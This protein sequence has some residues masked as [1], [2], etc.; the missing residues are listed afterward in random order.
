MIIRT[1]DHS[2]DVVWT[3]IETITISYKKTLV[4][5][6]QSTHSICHFDQA[7]FLMIEYVLDGI[8]LDR[9]G[10]QNEISLTAQT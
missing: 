2:D 3:R 1:C 6:H 4:K 7:P 9:N 5:S 8:N 10:H